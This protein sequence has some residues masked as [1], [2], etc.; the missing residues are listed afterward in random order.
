MSEA[1]PLTPGQTL[2]REHQVI[3]R[4]LR[5]LSRIVEECERDRIFPIDDLRQ[6]VRFFRLFADACHHGKE[7]DLLFPAM[8]KAGIARDNGPIGV[9]LYEHRMGRALVKRMSE[10]LDHY[11][12]GEGKSVAR[13]DR[14][15]KEYIHLLS[16]HIFKED[17]VLF[18]MGD[19]AISRED[20]Q[21]LC[22]QF[23]QADCRKFEGSDVRELEALADDLESRW[24]S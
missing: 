17:N 23:C 13:F 22:G 11:D 4:V 16:H 10:E 8:E 18:A 12:S 19:R 9:M 21:S 6:C 7:E 2:K 20:Q 14:A 15:A 5:V 24:K 1:S 3:L